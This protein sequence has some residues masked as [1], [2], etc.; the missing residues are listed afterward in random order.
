MR[1]VVINGKF[2]TAGMTGVHRVASEMV[3]GLDRLL[4][5]TP[6]APGQAPRIL[7]PRTIRN[8]LALNRIPVTMDGRLSWQF[9]EQFEL[10]GLARDAVLLGLCNL[11]PL[12]HPRAVTMIHDAQVFLTP[13]SYSP[14]FRAWYQFALPRIG[15]RAL[16]ILTVSEF[17]KTQ[18]VHYGVAEADRIEVIHNGADHIL[19][20]PADPGVVHRLGLV[21]GTYVVALANTQKHKNIRIL[22][23]A[24]RLRAMAGIRLVLIGGAT[25]ADFSEAGTPP[26]PDT[27]FAGKVSDAELRGLLESAG[28]LAFPSTTEGF[29]LPPLEAMLLG[30]PA[31]VA[32][33]GALPE[34]CGDAA[35]YA[36]AEDAEAWAT[37]IA[38][39]VSD[40]DLRR[41]MI[42]A[43]GRQA[44]RFSWD[45]AAKKLLDTLDSIRRTTS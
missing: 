38:S 29:G 16:K 7:A 21:P 44:A 30:C 14:Q 45:H 11:A 5:A 32:P 8:P 35:L 39:I 33:A 43:G 10:P 37:A 24:A 17:S 31:V 28:C 15:R 22:F 27:I 13:Q 18:L 1:S 42:E 36:D 20:T 41:R 6:P 9:W 40:P 19:R 25:A 4:D 3:S 2:L 12:S 23:Q 34:A 26:P